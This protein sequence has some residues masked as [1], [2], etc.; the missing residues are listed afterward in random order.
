MSGVIAN[1]V[2]VAI[3]EIFHGRDASEDDQ[4]LDLKALV[5][6]MELVQ[7]EQVPPRFRYIEWRAA[8]CLDSHFRAVLSRRRGRGI[9]SLR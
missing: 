7:G 9:Y 5:Q 4:G 6:P 3:E 2:G 8:P 1:D